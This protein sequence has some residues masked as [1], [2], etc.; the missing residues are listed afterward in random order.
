MSKDLTV[1][2]RDYAEID[3]RITKY[4]R[5]ELRPQSRECYD[6]VWQ[7]NILDGGGSTALHHAVGDGRMKVVQFQRPI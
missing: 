6:A 4:Q 2:V 3:R 7:Q 1:A 5:A